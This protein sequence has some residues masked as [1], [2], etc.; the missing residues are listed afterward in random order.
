MHEHLKLNFLCFWL[1]VVSKVTKVVKNAQLCLKNVCKGF[2][3]IEQ[4]NRFKAI[5]NLIEIISNVCFPA[6]ITKKA[7]Y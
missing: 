2:F 5:Q 7:A 3:P 4:I 1:S 6:P